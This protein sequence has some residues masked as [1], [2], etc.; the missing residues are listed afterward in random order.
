MK[1]YI[2]KY[3]KQ[4]LSKENRKQFDGDSNAKYRVV[5][6]LC[7]VGT[8]VSEKREFRHPVTGEVIKSHDE[9]ED[10]EVDGDETGNFYFQ[11]KIPRQ[12]DNSLGCTVTKQV[13]TRKAAI[14]ILK[15]I[16]AELEKSP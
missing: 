5:I 6:E 13:Y 9:D 3:V 1:D 16:I 12:V 14:G 2:L 4:A 11:I 7:E 10:Q 8:D 15:E